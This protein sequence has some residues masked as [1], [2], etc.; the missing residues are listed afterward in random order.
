M[1]ILICRDHLWLWF[2]YQ[3]FA[4]LYPQFQ[5]MFGKQDRLSVFVL[6]S[7]HLESPSLPSMM[8]SKD[9]DFFFQIL[10]TEKYHISLLK[11]DGRDL[12]PSQCLTVSVAVWH[13]HGSRSKMHIIGSMHRHGTTQKP[14]WSYPAQDITGYLCEYH[15]WVD[16]AS[17][18]CLPP[19]LAFF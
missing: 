9:L 1:F 17:C 10:R 13:C 4:S 19:K 15:R 5:W 11:S 7:S 12:P 6:V 18:M 14:L 8:T 3:K 16:M 2:S